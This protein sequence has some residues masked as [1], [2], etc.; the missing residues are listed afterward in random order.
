MLI[1]L[2]GFLEGDF[3]G[4]V[5]VVDSG[6]TVQALADQ[7][8]AWGPDLYPRPIAAPSVTNEHGV[9]LDPASTLTEAGLSGGDIFQV[10][11]PRQ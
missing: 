8:Q 7:L 9:V 10:R 11:G 6:R 3:L 5:I 2:Y 1:N 4:R